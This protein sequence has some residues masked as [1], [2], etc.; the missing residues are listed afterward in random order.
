M[1][2][3]S[4]VEGDLLVQR[5]SA[6][7]FIAYLPH[8]V[9]HA[10]GQSQGSLRLVGG[11]S[12]PRVASVIAALEAATQGTT[13]ARVMLVGHAHGGVTAA[14]LAASGASFTIEQVVTAGAP[15]AQVPRIPEATSLLALEDRADPVALL[16]S[17]INA[18]VANRLTVVFD[19]GESRG[20]AAYVVGGRAADQAGH[21]ELR[22]AIKRIQELGYLA[23]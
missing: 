3:L 1:S 20:P 15:S 2:S 23:S 16:G 22:A 18:S 12:S 5:V 13:D 7:R 19:G 8:G 4:R 6:N 9:G 11:D 21:P 10:N 14:E 17:L